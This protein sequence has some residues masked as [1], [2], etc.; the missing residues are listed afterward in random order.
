MK[1]ASQI[2]VRIGSDGNWVAEDRFSLDYVTPT[3]DTK[4]DVQLLFATDNGMNTSWGVI[5]PKDSCDVDDY[6]TENVS[7]TFLWALGASHSFDQHVDRGQ[8]HANL[9]S[10]IVPFAPLTGV[11]E[12]SLRMNATVVSASVFCS[13]FSVLFFLFSFFC[14]LFLF[15]F[16]CSR[17]LFLFMYICFLE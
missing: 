7:R 4:Q 15:L 5:L 8:F 12:V 2:V 17:C 1:G 3:L 10:A 6:S 11:T 16:S 9:V 13:L 14:S